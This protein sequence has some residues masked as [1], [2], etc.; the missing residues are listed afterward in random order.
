MSL[1]KV[2]IPAAYSFVLILALLSGTVKAQ[3]QDST[4]VS[5]TAATDSAKATNAVQIP[6][7]IS[8]DVDTTKLS[9]NQGDGR[10]M[11]LKLLNR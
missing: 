7:L 8:T 11:L 2:F 10:G 3:T 6:T 5:I 1:R 4:A 9:W